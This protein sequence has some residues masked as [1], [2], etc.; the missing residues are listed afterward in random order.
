MNFKNSLLFIDFA[1][2]LLNDLKFINNRAY[3]FI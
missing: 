3:F 1:S 2:I